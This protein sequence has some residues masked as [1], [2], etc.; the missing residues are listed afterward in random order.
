MWKTPKVT[1]ML[2]YYI[3]QKL[4]EIAIQNVCQECYTDI[5]LE[6]LAER[7]LPEWVEEFEKNYR[8]ENNYED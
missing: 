7:L 8:R 1:E 2:K 3:Q 6:D 5:I 4:Y